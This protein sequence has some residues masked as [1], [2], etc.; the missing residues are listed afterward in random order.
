MGEVERRQ[1]VAFL[2]PQLRRG[3]I[4]AEPSGTFRGDPALPPSLVQ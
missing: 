2:P 3:W 4:M 1:A